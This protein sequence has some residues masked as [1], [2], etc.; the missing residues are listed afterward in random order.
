MS[1]V[2]YSDSESDSGLPSPPPPSK[3]PRHAEPR[4]SGLPPLPASFHDLYAS[5]TR[6]S[7]QDDPSLHGGRKRVIPHV[8][9][10]WPT[11]LYL[12]WYPSK[13]VLPLLSDIIKKASKNRNDD[14]V[15]IHSLLHS[16][17]GAPLPLHISL[18]RPVVLR[19][20]QRASFTETL[21]NNIQQSRVPPFSVVPDSLKW[22]SN[23]EKTRWFL[24]LHVQKPVHDSLN[25][26]LCLSNR[27]LASFDQPPLY[28]PPLQGQHQ[29]A[30]DCSAYF[31][32]SLAWA[33]T[34]PS[35]RESED[36]AAT[37]LELLRGLNVRFDSV[38]AKIGNHVEMLKGRFHGDYEDLQAFQVQHFPGH[39]LSSLAP[40]TPTVEAHQEVEEDDLGYYPDGVKRTLTD[41]QIRIFRHS[42]VHALL[43]A[44]QLERDEAEY[45]ARRQLSEDGDSGARIASLKAN[46]QPC[47]DKERRGLGDINTQKLVDKSKMP[48]GGAAS[49]AGT[50]S[51]DYEEKES[52]PKPT[53]RKRLAE[54]YATYPRRKVVTYDD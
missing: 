20:E 38:K 41:E 50:E 36:I 25:R 4:A 40:V 5:T 46:D 16:D 23:Y 33:L 32:I 3:K 14:S 12:E 1:L 54:P 8:E 29:Q 48:V 24:V 35:P 53:D 47:E 37:D 42:E 9:G 19:T 18:S 44:R 21:L 34:E 52:E 26:L 45:E 15:R 6:V 31:H 10:N 49:I 27:S 51:L 17:L 39:S 43:R 11:H 28:T 13:E 22:V 2:Q 30:Q 7:V